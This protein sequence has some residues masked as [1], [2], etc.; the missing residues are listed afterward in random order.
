MSLTAEERSKARRKA[1]TLLEHMDRTEK[2]LSDRLG[3]AGFSP[4]AVADAMAY[5]SSYGYLN[6]ERYAENYISFR[7]ETKSRRKILQELVRKGIDQETASLA[8]EKAAEVIQPDE[9]EILKA[10][11]CKKYAPDTELDD[12][13]LRRLYGFLTRRGF[14]FGDISHVLEELHITRKK[15][16]DRTDSEDEHRD[17]E[18]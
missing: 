9:R 13:E 17:F 3:Q 1:M 7:M 18:I 5:V 10:A 15:Y 16:E 4:E 11:V 12:K 14:N 6:D 8:W 2:A